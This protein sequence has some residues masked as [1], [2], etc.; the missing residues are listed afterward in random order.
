VHLSSQDVYVSVAGGLT[1]DEP[2]VDLGIAAAV[3]SSLRNR[4]VDQTAVAIGEVGLA[5][6]IRDVSQLGTRIAEAARMGFRRVVTPRAGAEEQKRDGVEAV[7]A[8]DLSEALA[9]L[10]P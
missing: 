2:A 8:E 3:A 9:V 1:I 7:P 4:P 6:E 5:G 10:I